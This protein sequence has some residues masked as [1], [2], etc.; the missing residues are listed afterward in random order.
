[1]RAAIRGFP[2]GT[3]AQAAGIPVSPQPDEEEKYRKS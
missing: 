2:Q 3:T 1:M